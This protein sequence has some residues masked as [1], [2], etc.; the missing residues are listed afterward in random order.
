MTNTQQQYHPDDLKGKGEPGF[1]IDN[2]R[3]AREAAGI[4]RSRSARHSERRGEY[5]MV[6]QQP[7]RESRAWGPGK[8]GPP[9]LVRQRSASASAVASS[10]SRPSA[11]LLKEG[12]KRRLGSLKKK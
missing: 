9:V 11:S 5:E 7:P 10:S 4:G 3:K 1:T 12:L 6:S 2:E 8:D